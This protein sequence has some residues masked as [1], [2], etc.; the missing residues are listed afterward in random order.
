MESS[1]Q[2]RSKRKG[3]IERSNYAYLSSDQREGQS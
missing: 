1:S 2:G 3:Q